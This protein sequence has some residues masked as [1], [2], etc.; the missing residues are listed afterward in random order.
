MNRSLGNSGLFALGNYC[1]PVINLAVHITVVALMVWVSVNFLV[2]QDAH[3]AILWLANGVTLGVLLTN[4][5]RYWPAYLFCGYAANVAIGLATGGVPISTA[6][7]SCANV[8]EILVA[9]LAVYRPDRPAHHFTDRASALRMLGGFL[10][11]PAVSV[12]LAAVLRYWLLKTPWTQTVEI[13]YVAHSLGLAIV[14]PLTLTILFKDFD[15]LIK[16]SQLPRTVSMLLLLAMVTVIVF[17]QT[18]LPLLF[19]VFPFMALVV[20]QL[21]FPGMTVGLFSVAVGVS[22]F[23][24]QGWGPFVLMQRG[25]STE[26]IW[27]AQFYI[28]TCIAMGVPIAIALTE[29]LRLERSL[30]TAQEQLRQLAATDQLTGIPN[31][32]MFDEFIDREWKRSLRD[33]TTLCAIMIDVDCFKLYNDHYGHQAG[34]DCLKAV[35]LC[36]VEVVRRPGDLVARYGGEE[37]VVLLPTTNLEGARFVAEQICRRVEALQIVHSAAS[38]GRVTVSLGVDV[39]LPSAGG[40]P[41]DLIASADKLL[42]SAK[43]KG[44]NRVCDGADAPLLKKRVSG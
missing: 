37:F 39:A 8:V 12:V 1:P 2:A 34:D 43:E 30:L 38:D 41:E 42:Y 20:F 25:G 4:P 18:E 32:R 13:W 27:F 15:P 3:I 7:I 23:T 24:L 26:R 22:F 28:F 44:R 35:A 14:T 31:R 17:H 9:A 5:R 21:G 40:N 36:L 16:R 6:T 29:R 33:K 10:L 19:L 11:G